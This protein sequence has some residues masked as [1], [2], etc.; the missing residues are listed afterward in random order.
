MSDTLQI[1][2]FSQKT[3]ENPLSH[4]MKQ[5]MKANYSLIATF[6]YIHIN[7]C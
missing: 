3:T 4:H 5:K 6:A 2:Y 1:M 7:L